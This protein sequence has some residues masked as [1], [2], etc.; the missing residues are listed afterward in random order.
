MIHS[1]DPKEWDPFTVWRTI[2][3]DLQTVRWSLSAA[4]DPDWIAAFQNARTEK[5]GSPEYVMSGSEPTISGEDIEWSV[6][7]K[8][9]LDANL[10]VHEKVDVANSAYREVLARRD[11][12]RERVDEEK[13]V[14]DAAIEEAQRQLDEVNG[15]QG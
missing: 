5:S 3:V 8:D 11:L 13:R 15:S 6:G 2:V 4:P 9:H 12:E 1:S 7:P 14:R 10:R